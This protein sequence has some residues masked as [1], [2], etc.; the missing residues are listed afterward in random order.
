MATYDGGVD[1]LLGKRVETVL[2]NNRTEEVYTNRSL[3]EFNDPKSEEQK[4]E[5]K[6]RYAMGRPGEL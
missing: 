4:P 1:P 5:D 3:E 2:T 6:Y